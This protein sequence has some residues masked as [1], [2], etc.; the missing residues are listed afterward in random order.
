M[1]L[2]L[3]LW[4][5]NGLAKHTGEVKNNVQNQQVDIMLISETRFT[6]KNYFKS[7]TTQSMTLNT[8]MAVHME[9]LLYPS[10]TALK[11]TSMDTT[12]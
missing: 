1:Q 5:A 3:V 4:N 10:K 6:T 11:I 7:H 12:T 8:P 9:E 2:K